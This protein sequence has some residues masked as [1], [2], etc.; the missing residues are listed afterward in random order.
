MDETAPTQPK[1]V[2][3]PSSPQRPFSR[4]MRTDQNGTE[5]RTVVV[6][7][8]SMALDPDVGVEG[9]CALVRK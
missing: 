9:P 1:S 6:C 5:S 4:R 8:I 3:V 2:S 7:D